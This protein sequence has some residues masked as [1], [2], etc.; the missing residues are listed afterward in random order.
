MLIHVALTGPPRVILGRP[1]LDLT[2][3]GPD[4][5]L[6]DLLAALA[7][8]EPRVARYLLGEDRRSSASLRA[9]L[10]DHIL[11]PDTPI[12]NGAT[13]TLLYAVAGGNSRAAE[14]RGAH[15]ADIRLRK[16]L[17]C[18]TNR[19]QRGDGGGLLLRIACHGSFTPVLAVVTLPSA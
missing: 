14:V 5:T 6:S 9:L 19:L 17:T 13:V 16:E 15:L 18:S 8:A 7:D 2:L 12:P 4:C 10:D 1:T 3:P 11:A